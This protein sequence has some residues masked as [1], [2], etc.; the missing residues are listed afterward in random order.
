MAI[1]K[2][3]FQ[4]AI[5]RRMNM[6]TAVRLSLVIVAITA[7]LLNSCGPKPT[8]APAPTKA[9][10]ATQAP[11]PTKAP[12]PTQPSPTSAEKVPVTILSM[13]ADWLLASLWDSASGEETPMLKEFEDKYGIDVIFESYPEDTARQK[14]MLDLSSHTGQYDIITTGVW[15][16]A[17]YASADYLEPLDDWMADK[18]AP[19][20]FSMDDYLPA[21]L[22]GGSYEGHVYSLPLYTFGGALVYNKELFE[23]YNVK[24]PETIEELEEAAEKLTL[25]LDDDGKADIYGITMRAR[26]GE[27]P[28]I[29]V[30]GMS[31]AFGGT[32]FEGNAHTAEE[33]RANKAR[34]TVNSPEFIAGYEEYAK[35]LQNWGPPESANWGWEECMGAL[36]Q[37][38]AAM[39]LAATSAYWFT[40]STATIDPEAIGIAHSPMGPGGHRM[41]N[42]F[43]M[44]L[45][46]N[47]D[48]KHK[49]EAWLVLQFVTSNQVQKAQA[50]A[51]ITAIPRISLILSDEL[52]AQ[53]PEEDLQVV[54][55]TLREAEPEYMPKIPEYVELCDILGTAASEVVAGTKTAEEAL[56]EAQEEITQIMEDAGYYD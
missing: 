8:E 28:T 52:K 46:I 56:N 13:G 44:A 10:E 38:K 31:W 4:K 9:P 22:E 2:S 34:P 1:E 6:K 47:R 16:M 11:E 23:K 21:S 51:G 42:F 40:R 30:T 18:A 12:E 50:E 27:E 19:E 7:L 54:L 26:R 25:D 53:Y 41:M 37:G 17:T 36:A 15:A 48:S 33:I 49:E 43:D 3:L 35:L 39:H 45:S 24:V 14:T 55:D 29:D 5:S 32:W 20:F